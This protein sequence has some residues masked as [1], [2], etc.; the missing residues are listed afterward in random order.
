[1][2]PGPAV[3][4]SDFQENR[5]VI[6]AADWKLVLRSSLTYV[7]FDL[8]NDP[9]E[10]NEL[11]GRRNPIAMRYLRIMSGQFLGARN[12]TRWL[13][14]TADA[15]REHVREETMTEE[16]CRQLVA[17]GYMECLGQFPGAGG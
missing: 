15:V 2:A 5:R 7:L 3:A 1:M 12:R 14:G 13:E 8:A 4:F 9:N 17:L 16:L 11:D 10:R 6:R